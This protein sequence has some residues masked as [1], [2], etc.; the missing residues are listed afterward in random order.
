MMMMMLSLHLLAFF[1]SFHSSR[2]HQTRCSTFFFFSLTFHSILFF[3]F[4]YI[5]VLS[6]D[7]RSHKRD[8]LK[9][10]F[11][12]D[13][14]RKRGWWKKKEKKLRSRWYSIGI[15]WLNFIHRSMVREEVF[16]TWNSSQGVW[17]SIFKRNFNFLSKWLI[18]KS[19][20]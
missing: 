13:I 11:F 16:S 17:T 12:S 2:I 1:H 14:R 19:G 4:C 6:F 8:E 7:R 20:D 10:P 18:L 15:E 5:V 3:F 9:V